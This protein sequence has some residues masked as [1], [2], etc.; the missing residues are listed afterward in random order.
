M[1][2]TSIEKTFSFEGI[3]PSS[4]STFNRALIIQ[5]YEPQI[6]VS[7]D[8]K[9]D[10]IEKM[11]SAIMNLNRHESTFD[12]GEAGTVLRF[13]ALRISR[14]SGNFLLTG[15]PRLFKRPQT[16][17]LQIFS[18]FQVKY[19]ME[20][21]GL[22]IESK[23][24][25]IP[26]KPLRVSARESSQF[27]SGIFLNCWNLPQEIEIEIPTEIV[28]GAYFQLTQEILKEFGMEWHQNGNV[29]VV[30]PDQKPKVQN[31]R[32]ESDLS[33]T[34]AVVA[35]ALVAGSALIKQFPFG[36]KQ[37]DIAFVEILKSMGATLEQRL[38][39]LWVEKATRL[40]A[41]DI[42]L[43]NAPD[44][45]PVLSALSVSAEGVTVL[46]GAPQLKYKESNRIEEVVTLLQRLGVHAETREDGAVVYGQTARNTNEVLLDAKDDHRLVMMGAVLKATGFIIKIENSESTTKSFPEFLE[47]AKGYL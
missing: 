26:S 35:L 44:L 39:D 42:N 17:L 13:L 33:S 30:P 10:D 32:V 36:S 15:K 23:G 27:L 24:W 28:S 37:P 34:F 9:C 4:K 21:R 43:I 12:C 29:F 11:R 8:G 22:R 16:E 7:G 6:I 46:H 25:K 1:E 47:I 40:R 18:Q 14:N 38:G 41:Q 45:F 31:Y 2:N 3:I 19:L 5:S 20:D